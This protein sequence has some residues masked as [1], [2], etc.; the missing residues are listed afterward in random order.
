MR[1][2]PPMLEG[3]VRIWLNN[4]REGS[5]NYWLDFED[6]FVSNFSSTY[7]RPNRPHQLAMCRQ[8]DNETNQDYLTGWNTIRNSC[9]GVV[10]AQA[11]SWF[12]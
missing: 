7:R 12:V 4:L 5:V 8:R 9:E 11:I 10:E 2:I 3:P 6:A 1:Y